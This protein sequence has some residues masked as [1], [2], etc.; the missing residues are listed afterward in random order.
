MESEPAGRFARL[1]ARFA[2]G[3]PAPGELRP[4][5]TAAKAVA[6]AIAAGVHLFTLA[7]FGAGAATLV[8]YAPNLLAI[9]L[10]LAL[11]G[12][13]AAMRPRVP[14]MPEG[15]VL[16]DAPALHGAGPERRGRAEP[17]PA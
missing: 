2:D 13:A 8:V 9:L 3:M 4:R 12:A 16:A 7:L 14:P 10:G 17:S 6:Y 15:A 11:L 1:A 5:L